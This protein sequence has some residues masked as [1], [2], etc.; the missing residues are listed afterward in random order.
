MV[1]RY[2]EYGS[3]TQFI[4]RGGTAVPGNS[5]GTWCNNDGINLFDINHLNGNGWLDNGYYPMPRFGKKEI[6]IFLDG[7]IQQRTSWWGGLLGGG[8]NL[9]LNLFALWGL[10]RLFGGRARKQTPAQPTLSTNR[11]ATWYSTPMFHNAA[12]TPVTTIQTQ[13][14]TQTPTQT[15][16]QTSGSGNA[17]A[18]GPAA[19][20]A[21]APAGKSTTVTS[22]TATATNHPNATE[23]ITGTADQGEG[24]DKEHKYPKT[25]TITDPTH[26]KDTGN[27]NGNIYTFTFVTIDNGK[28]IYKCTQFKGYATENA[29][30]KKV[31]YIVTSGMSQKEGSEN[32][33]I[34]SNITMQA[35][36]STT[37]P[38]IHLKYLTDKSARYREIP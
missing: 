9:G 10:G 6:N 7:G 32:Y 8:I 38:I 18:A 35:V 14:Q 12:T 34:T 37:G 33:D 22:Y 5:W 16:T 28:P 19:T 25:F 15:P 30:I 29:T 31:E 11:F 3:S 17:G 36:E 2:V 24:Y 26:N 27:P 1:D 4:P 21:A 13:T 20:R 23:P